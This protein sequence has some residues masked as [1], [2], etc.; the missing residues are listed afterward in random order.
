VG[1][2]EKTG[3]FTDLGRWAI[4]PIGAKFDGSMGAFKT[5]SV[6]DAE[7]TGPYMHDGSLKTLEEVVEH[8]DKGGNANPALDTDM[9]KLSLSAQEKTDVVAFMKSL[10]GETKK[11]DELLPTL[12]SDSGGKSPDAR[13]ALTPPSKSVAAVLFH[14]AATR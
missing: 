3:K 5:P 8:Y 1:W 2:N 10:T 13:A 9:K 6:R 14:P 12:P 11:L 7:S 4:D